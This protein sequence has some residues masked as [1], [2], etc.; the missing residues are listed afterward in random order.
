MKGFQVSYCLVA[1][2]ANIAGPFGTPF[3][4]LVRGIEEF[5]NEK[6]VKVR[7]SAFYTSTSFPNNSKPRYINGCLKIKVDC[8]PYEVLQR[9]KR[10]EEKMGRLN[11]ERWDSRVCDLDLLAF[12]NEVIP[13]KKIFQYWYK[14]SLKNQFLEKPSEL[15]V[16][17]PRIQDRAFVLKP[18]L[19]VAPD[20]THP[21]FNLNVKEMFNF[22]SQ[23]KRDD[24]LKF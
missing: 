11:G 6:L 2:G 24:V 17:H 18:L 5:P 22:L 20:W 9:L 1:F 21:V 10:I 23:T 16:P 12:E 3:Q 8:T 4:T 14:L 7:Q 19:E 15:L 13:N